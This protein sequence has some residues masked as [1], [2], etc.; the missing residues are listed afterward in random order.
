M[1]CRAAADTRF[2]ASR[3]A[4]VLGALL[5]GCGDTAVVLEIRSDLPVPQELDG[6]C[7]SAAALDATGDE[8]T[9]AETYLLGG[10]LGALPQTLTLLPGGHDR[11]AIWVRGL[12]GGREVARAGEIARFAPRDVVELSVDLRL[13]PVTG[14]GASLV[15]AGRASLSDAHAAPILGW[16]EVFV[17]AV[18]SG[19]SA[20]LRPAS[21]DFTPQAGVPT[22]PGAIARTLVFDADG[23]CDDDVAVVPVTGPAEL[24]RQDGDGQYAPWPGAFPASAAFAALA[25]GD[26]DR[27]GDVDLVAGAGSVLALLRNDGAG[28]FT[29]DT[30]AMPLGVVS[31]V[32]ALALGDVTG[33]G[34]PDVVVGQGGAGPAPNRVLANDPA[35]TGFFAPAPGILPD[36]GERT[37]HVVLADLDADGDL[38][39]VVAGAGAPI[40]LYVNRGDGRLEDRSFVRLPTVEP[41]DVADV[42]VGDLDGD[43]LPDLLFAPL[44]G[45]AVTLWRGTGTAAF[46]PAPLPAEA[47]GAR[48]AVGDAEGDGRQDLLVA[49]ADGVTWIA[50]R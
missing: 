37:S 1:P 25:S 6:L 9:F 49:D 24:W 22:P 34:H 31:D 16:R 45:G 38:D 46:A 10:D 4:L 48:V 41:A 32:T 11:A 44:G 14:A 21:G 18:G 2:T 36:V 29:E 5:C 35:G 19:G 30:G 39:L 8:G 17:L 12:R 3:L 20:R 27:D 7:V 43:C 42:A 47:A 33:D 40:R 50:P 26:V 13:C 15:V 23:D 28:R